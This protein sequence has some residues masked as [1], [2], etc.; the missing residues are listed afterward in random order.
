MLHAE[1]S[2]ALNVASF[3][4]AEVTKSQN[5][6]TYRGRGLNG[7]MYRRLNHNGAPSKLDE[8]RKSAGKTPKWS[9]GSDRHHFH[10]IQ[11]PF[12]QLLWGIIVSGGVLGI[13]GVSPNISRISMNPRWNPP[14]S[15]NQIQCFPK[16]VHGCQRPRYDES[17]GDCHGPASTFPRGKDPQKRRTDTLGEAVDIRVEVNRGSH[18]DRTE[19]ESSTSVI[20]SVMVGVPPSPLYLAVVEVIGEHPSCGTE[21]WR[22]GKT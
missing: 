10:V 7:I 14:M 2:P 20:G 22:I 18:D 21:V 16:D 15:M 6:F 9:R 1:S 12:P 5:F 11:M 3:S 17:P 8:P 19:G 4:E 13:H